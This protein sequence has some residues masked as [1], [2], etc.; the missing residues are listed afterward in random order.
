MVFEKPAFCQLR[1]S[2]VLRKQAI[3]VTPRGV[4]SI[5]QRN[6][7]EDFNKFLKGLEARV[8]QD[9]SCS[10]K[11]SLWPWNARRSSERLP[12]RS[13][14]ST[15]DTSLPRTEKRDYIDDLFVKL[16]QLEISL[17]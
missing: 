6:E 16:G 2:N 4:R 7:L 10:P 1:V 3:F 13:I 9:G 5:L 15:P 17:G 12:V 11:P 8:A 14:P